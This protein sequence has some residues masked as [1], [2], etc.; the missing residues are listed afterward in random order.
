[1]EIW[2]KTCGLPLLV[3]FE[4][5]P[6]VVQV[7]SHLLHG[8]GA[9]A[10][11][12]PQRVPP[13]QARSAHGRPGGL[14]RLPSDRG[15]AAAQIMGEGKEGPVLFLGCQLE[16]DSHS[17]VKLQKDTRAELCILANSVPLTLTESFN[18]VPLS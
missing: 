5:H 6:D 17:V 14:P 12:G 10:R 18:L 8:H 11:G 1:M 16:R 9:G 2:T 13:E 15:W 7:I 4:P 3:N